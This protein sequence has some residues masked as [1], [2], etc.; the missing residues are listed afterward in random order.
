MRINDSFVIELLKHGH[1]MTDEQIGTLL[2]Q[3]KTENKPLQEMALKA[4]L[5]SEKALAHL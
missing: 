1:K 2:E 3:Q 5:V 4:N